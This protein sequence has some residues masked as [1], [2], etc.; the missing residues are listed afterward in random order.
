[1]IIRLRG[2]EDLGATFITAL[3]R[4]AGEL[5]QAGAT[6]ML[7]GISQST[8]D[9]LAATKALD[10]IGTEQIFTATPRIGDSLTAALT[11][12]AR[13]QTQRPRRASGS[14]WRRCRRS[15]RR[16]RRTA[17]PAIS[18]PANYAIAGIR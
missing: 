15:M 12:A 1:V 13:N 17:A 10:T 6:L 8:L 14:Q 4:Y 2:K 11:A 16:T 7:A 5:R 3:V 18:N 9:Q